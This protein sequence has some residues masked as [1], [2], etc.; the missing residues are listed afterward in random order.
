MAALSSGGTNWRPWSTYNSGAYR[1]YLTGG[2]AASVGGSGGGGGGGVNVPAGLGAALR[3]V[4]NFPIQPRF[5]AKLRN[6]IRAQGRVFSHAESQASDIDRLV[7]QAERRGD[8]RGAADLLGVKLNDEKQMKKAAQAALRGYKRELKILRHQ[9]RTTPP[10]RRGK[11]VA[12]IKTIQGRIADLKGTVHEL[13]FDIGDTKLDI[14]DELDQATQAADTGGSGDTSASDAAQAQADLAQQMAA[15]ADE[16][17]RQN[18]LT[19]GVMRITTA[20]AVKAFADLISGQ[21]AGVGYGP[22][23]STAGAGSVARY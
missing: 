23:A 17:K 6:S 20:Q 12:M 5:P 15:I 16:L 22:R 9:L 21:I 2:P 7:S 3:G 18:D 8:Y 4:T 10:G 1:R 13:G 14:K 11:I 19:Q